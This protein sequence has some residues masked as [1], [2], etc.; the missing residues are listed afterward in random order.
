V[1]DWLT[2][3]PLDKGGGV[4]L[5]DTGTIRLLLQTNLYLSGTLEEVC[6]TWWELHWRPVSLCNICLCGKLL[7][8]IL[9][10][11]IWM[12]HASEYQ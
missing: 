8:V 4:W 2:Q 3:E 5:A 12:K 1:C 11:S 7:C 10:V 9:P 6:R